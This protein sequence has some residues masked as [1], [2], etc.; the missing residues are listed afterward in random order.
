MENCSIDDSSTNDRLHLK[1]NR[2]VGHVFQ[3]TLDT[4]I[5]LKPEIAPLDVQCQGSFVTL[6]ITATPDQIRAVDKL[7]GDAIFQIQN[8][9]NVSRQIENHEAAKRVARINQLRKEL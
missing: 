9:A 2:P 7:I 4:I 3:N 5:Q 1:V 6:P 8:D